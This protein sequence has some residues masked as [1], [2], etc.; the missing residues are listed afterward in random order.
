MK[1]KILYKTIF[2][3]VLLGAVVSVAGQG[4]IKFSASVDKNR[5]LIGEP[6]VL[7]LEADVPENEAIRF[8]SLDTIPHFEFLQKNKIDTVNTSEGTVLRQL[9]RITSFDSGHWVIP[10]L[11]LDEGLATDSIPVDVVFSSPFDPNQD[12]HDIKDVLAVEVEKNEEWWW[13]YAIGG[14]LIVLVLIVYFL[15]EGKPEK[16][17]E[18]VTVN[19]Y[20]EAM[21]ELEKLRKEK[22]GAKQYYTGVVDIFRI[23]VWRKKGITSLQKTT[24]DLVIQIRNLEMPRN[25][26]EQ[27]AQSLRLSDFVKFA[28]YQ[29]A[30]ADDKNILETIRHSITIIERSEP[31][32]PASEG[33]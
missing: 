9:I 21:K 20:E 24:D 25:D 32:L 28:K 17:P 13:W 1:Y 4:G 6:I 3:L 12:Y 11:V 30:E 16:Q 23:Y 19:P 8:F 22:Y 33:V 18:V 2:S 27:L 5:I 26:F 10:P 14:S 29:P 15:T 31:N 7:R